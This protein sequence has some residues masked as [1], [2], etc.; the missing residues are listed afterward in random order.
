MGDD[1]VSCWHQEERLT[2]TVCEAVK[3][4]RNYRNKLEEKMEKIKR[5][6]S[7][8]SLADMSNLLTLNMTLS[9]IKLIFENCT[10]EL[11]R[12]SKQKSSH[13]VLRM[14]TILY[15]SILIVAILG[16]M[17]PMSHGIDKANTK[18]NLFILLFQLSFRA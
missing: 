5:N 2:Q 3:C 14:F 17:S 1:K 7:W 8:P 16:Q 10:V 13:N 18:Y 11:K 15:C 4:W 6:K 12:K 9:F